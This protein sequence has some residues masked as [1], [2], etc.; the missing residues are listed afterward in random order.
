M[1]SFE[2]IFYVD[3]KVF[4]AS[5]FSVLLS[6]IPLFRSCPFRMGHLIFLKFVSYFPHVIHGIK[7]EI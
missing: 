1:L 3:F 7:R 4:F 6:G 2:E 5:I